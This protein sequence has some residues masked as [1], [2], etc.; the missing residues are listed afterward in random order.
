M[1]QLRVIKNSLPR[2]NSRNYI[3]STAIR[4]YYFREDPGWKVKVWDIASVSFFTLLLLVL[5]LGEGGGGPLNFLH[6]HTWINT[7]LFFV[8]LREFSSLKIDYKRTILNPAQL[9]SLS[10]LSIILIGSFLLML[11]RATHS[12]ISFLDAIFT[13]T[14]A[15]CVTGLIVVDTATHF[16]RLGQTIILIL[17]QVGGLGI[18]TFASYFSYFFRGRSSYEN[19]L[20]VS[21]M[22][23][24]QKIGEAF[25]VLKTIILV[26]FLIEGIGALIIF[27]TLN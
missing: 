24:D 19:H 14:S 6:H 7:G 1:D 3:A 5:I 25:N 26:T 9:F 23:Q 15:V 11:P 21:A 22:T 27:F 18:M 17:I 4:Y 12:G 8:F 13:S 2:P 16:T 10:F 20:M